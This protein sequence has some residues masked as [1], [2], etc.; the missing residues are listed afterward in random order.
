M[1]Q[2]KKRPPRKTEAEAALPQ[3]RS[4]G[5]MDVHY[6]LLRT[7]PGYAEARVASENQALRAALSPIIGRTGCTRIPVVVH[8]VH[9][10]SAQNI[11]DAQVQSQIDVLNEDFRQK[12]GDLSTA[13]APFGAVAADARIEFKLATVDPAGNPTNG[14]TRTAT[15]TTSFSDDDGVKSSAT[16]GAD[17]WPSDKYLNIWVCPLGGGL[18]GYA[19]FPGGPAATDGVVILHSAFGNTG[20]AAAPF[21]LGRSAT[22][23]IGHWLNLRHIWGDDG[24]GCAGS[25]FVA[26]TPNQGGPNFGV[27]TFPKVSCGNAPNGDMFVDFM[28]YVDD[29]AMVMFTAGQVTRMQATLDGLRSSIGTTISCDGVV[30]K[31]EPDTIKKHEPDTIKKLEPDV[32]KLEPDTVKK[33]EPDTIK[34][35]EPDIKKLEPDT[36]KKHEPDTV[37]KHEPDTVKKFEPEIKKHEPDTVKKHEPDVKKHEP[38]TIKKFEPD[39]PGIGKHE[40]EGPPTGPGPVEFAYEQRYEER[41][42]RIEAALA[43]LTHFIQQSQRPDV[44]RAPLRKEKRK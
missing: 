19:Q 2:K 34:K 16:G 27:P 18:L 42:Q 39:G 31:L 44:S 38:D 25:D 6:R 4:C 33:H 5:T 41:L 37:K 8:V 23:E 3:R 28:D 35:H 7:A 9:K 40:P 21:N 15:A 13:P 1:A 30:K 14:I 29:A 11:S 22:H 26:D 36:V 24:N 12:N 32:K 20:T 43:Q 10:T 17:P